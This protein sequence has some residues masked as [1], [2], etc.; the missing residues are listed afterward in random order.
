MGTQ[1]H[2]QY[3]HLYRTLLADGAG[4]AAVG[5][6][7]STGGRADQVSGGGTGQHAAGS[8]RHWRRRRQE[9]DEQTWRGLHAHAHAP[10]TAFGSDRLN[11]SGDFG[12][13]FSQVSLPRR[14]ALGMVSILHR[15]RG[16]SVTPSL[17]P[18]RANTPEVASEDSRTRFRSV[19]RSR[20]SS[21]GWTTS[22]GAMLFG[23]REESVPV[24]RSASSVS[25]VLQ[26]SSGSLPRLQRRQLESIS[27]PSPFMSTRPISST[28]S[29]HKGG[30]LLLSQPAEL[31]LDFVDRFHQ[32]VRRTGG[33]RA[34]GTF[35]LLPLTTPQVGGYRAPCH[36]LY[37]SLGGGAGLGAWG[38]ATAHSLSY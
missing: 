2:P 23:Q 4:D 37:H 13:P 19:D 12:A 36:V 30:T 35:A 17:R 11:S 20:M 3:D 8:P 28:E 14:P 27:A 22:L 6:T 15:M 5:L 33:R 1:R 26:A 31:A 32:I 10:L 38:L 34:R 9:A 21:K 7:Y 18:S 16:S 29:M 25:G 24:A